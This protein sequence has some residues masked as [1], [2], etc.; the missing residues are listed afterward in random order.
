M[1]AS[2][3]YM[4]KFLGLKPILSITVFLIPTAYPV[5]ILSLGGQFFG[6]F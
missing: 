1:S 5:N 4:K 2:L 6:S 3:A